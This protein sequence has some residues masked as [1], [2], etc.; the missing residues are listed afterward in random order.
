MR[1]TQTKSCL[2]L[3]SLKLLSINAFKDFSIVFPEQH[4]PA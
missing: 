2:L 4:A 3:F 1:F